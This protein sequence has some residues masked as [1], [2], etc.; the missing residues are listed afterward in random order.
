MEE[1]QDRCSLGVLTSA[2][3]AVRQMSSQDIPHGSV[4]E[5]SIRMPVICRPVPQVVLHFIYRPSK[6]G[7]NLEVGS[8]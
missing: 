6:D 4:D 8:K 7:N 3:P 5:D 1:I 2:R